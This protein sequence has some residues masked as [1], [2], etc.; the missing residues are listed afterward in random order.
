[1]IGNFRIMMKHMKWT[2]KTV[3]F[4][5]IAKLFNILFYLIFGAFYIIDDISYSK[6]T[7]DTLDGKVQNLVILYVF[8][9]FAL[10][11]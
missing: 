2:S 10:Q 6:G 7:N 1:M 4:Y 8:S 11:L 9:G 3:I 5:K